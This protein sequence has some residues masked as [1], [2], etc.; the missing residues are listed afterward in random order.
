MAEGLKNKLSNLN[1]PPPDG[2]WDGIKARLDNEYDRGDAIVRNKVFNSAVT[3]PA[4]NFNKIKEALNSTTSTPVVKLKAINA[5]YYK[6]AVAAVILCVVS[7]AAFYL[8]NFRLPTAVNDTSSAFPVFSESKDPSEQS[9][10]LPDNNS[11]EAGLKKEFVNKSS[12]KIIP[13]SREEVPV[14]YAGMHYSEPYPPGYVTIN[15]E[16]LIVKP[17]TDIHVE[18]PPLRDENGAII[19]DM[20][21]VKD[22]S[23]DFM[24]VTGPN[25]KQV[26][27]SEKF[28]DKIRYLNKTLLPVYFD[29]E[30]FK[31][32]YQFDEWRETLISN[33]D[34][35]PTAG[36]Y[37]DILELKNM[38]QGLD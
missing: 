23:G 15:A 14:Q 35:I 7:A 16:K 33:T 26:R 37:F 10:N 20:E 8:F 31:W 6:V 9:I 28:A 19:L 2:S 13:E 21:L 32:S 11:S 12:K 34:F 25:G 17:E 30:A 4:D 5:P 29:I 1:F 36:N 18:A 24:I 38:I 3:P 27:L 22:G